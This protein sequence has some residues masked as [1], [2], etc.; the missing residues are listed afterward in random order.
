[1]PRM[2]PSCAH[3]CPASSSAPTPT[4]GPT[5]ATLP[6]GATVTALDGPVQSDDLSWYEVGWGEVS[7]WI[8]SGENGDWLSAI[9]N[10]R[11]AFACIRCSDV[12]EHATVVVEPDGSSMQLFHPEFGAVTWSPDGSRAVIEVAG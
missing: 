2:P 11:I 9:Q 12:P 5:R 8:A 4:P 6:A 7:G 3:A 1:M 10:G